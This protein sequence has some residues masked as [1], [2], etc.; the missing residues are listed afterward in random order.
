MSASRT[1]EWYRNHAL[2]LVALVNDTLTGLAE[3]GG[4]RD[5]ASAFFENIL[6]RIA[7]SGAERHEAEIPVCERARD[8]KS[9]VEFHVARRVHAEEV[10]KGRATLSV[11]GNGGVRVSWSAADCIYRP[12]CE[13]TIAAGLSCACAERLCMEQAA[14][15]ETGLPV[16]SNLISALSDDVCVFDVLPSTGGEDPL[17]VRD[18]RET[19][20]AEA[21][22]ED[23]RRSNIEAQHQMLLETI[24]DAIVVVDPDGR[25]TYV[26]PRACGVFGV[27]PEKAAGAKFTKGGP[28]G[29]IGDLCLE[30]AEELGGW[31]GNIT[32]ENR[33]GETIHNIY[34]TRF[35]PIYSRDHNRIGT[36][37]VL[38]DITREELLRRKV[39]AQTENLE[40]AVRDKTR[41]LQEANAK[42]E[43]LAR[44]DALTGLANRR[45]FEEVLR[46]EL[47]RA[48]RYK[49]PTGVLMVDV[50]RFKQVNDTLGHQT[51]DLVLK[52]VASILAKSVRASDTLA[53]WGGDEFILLLPQAGP[54]ECTAVARRIGENLLIENASGEVV[55]GLGISLSL[56][57]ATDT[58]GNAETLVAHADKMMYENK[59]SKKK[60]ARTA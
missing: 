45:T 4:S 38:D 10:P 5:G 20:E 57:W 42:L 59:T 12:H 46:S 60:V 23:E 39:V 6:R 17:D 28:L 2:S 33:D 43:I 26:N 47:I 11:L 48:G 25:V 8:V 36:M 1:K 19:T 41:E 15:V 40:R 22:R 31:L 53:R 35:S 9:A 37:I 50:D 55:S 44:T 21:R 18:K 16:S 58:G 27:P 30:A 7:R 34:M 51:G 29:R 52:Y 3:A 54:V 32:I 56:G 49:H 13:K 24:A 14:A